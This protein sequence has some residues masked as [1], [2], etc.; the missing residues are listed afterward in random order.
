MGDLWG[1]G[2]FRFFGDKHWNEP[3]RWN[4]KATEPETVFC[5]SMGDLFFP[6]RR[7]D[8]YRSRLWTIVESTPNL[9][10]L[11]LTKYI[12]NVDR[13]VPWDRFPENVCLMTTIE[14]QRVWDREIHQL[15]EFRDRVKWIGVSMEPLLSL[16]WAEISLWSMLDWVIV[17][18]E[19]GHHAREMPLA[20]C[21]WTIGQARGCG[22][23]VFVKQMGTHWAKQEGLY[24]TDPKG[25]KMER[26]PEWARVKEEPD[27]SA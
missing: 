4:R 12:E 17:G 11:F 21:R 23:R 18:G 24:R 25:E 13:M 22:A 6:D 9:R 7:L 8:K 27:W 5:M 20:K 19:S 2:K 16:V 14:N 3:I 26:W 10:W 1:Q 15:I